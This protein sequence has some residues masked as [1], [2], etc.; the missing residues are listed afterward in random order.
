MKIGPLST[1]EATHLVAQSHLGRLGCLADG[2]PYVVPVYYY[3]DGI[4]S[5]YLH[6]LPGLKIE[7]LRSNPQA[8]LQVDEIEDAFHWRSAIVYGTYQEIED[9]A[10]REQ[11]LARLFRHLPH[12]SPVESKMTQVDGGAIVFRIHVNEITG[13]G[14]T[15]ET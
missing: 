3:F 13:V 4:S 5:V 10:E 15:W 12:L 11:I 8:C 14:E 6:S 9:P 1:A 2:R 7:S